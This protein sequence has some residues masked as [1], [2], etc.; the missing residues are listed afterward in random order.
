MY[1]FYFFCSFLQVGGTFAQWKKKKKHY[2]NGNQKKKHNMVMNKIRKL[3]ISRRKINK[4]YFMIEQLKNPMMKINRSVFHTFDW[5][6]LIFFITWI[7]RGYSRDCRSL[8]SVVLYLQV[9]FDSHL[10]W[11]QFPPYSTCNLLSPIFNK[12][13]DYTYLHIFFF[14]FYIFIYIKFFFF[15]F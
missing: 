14:L 3:E 8:E 2:K 4:T 10:W 13:L 5:E 9:R 12:T 1:I 6:F 15:L 11:S 7:Y